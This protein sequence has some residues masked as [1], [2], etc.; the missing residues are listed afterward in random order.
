MSTPSRYSVTTN[1]YVVTCATCRTDITRT[2]DGGRI[3]N[4]NQ[5]DQASFDHERAVHAIPLEHGTPRE[6]PYD[7]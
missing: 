1:V 4:L 2:Q 7:R 3:F 6:P 5:A